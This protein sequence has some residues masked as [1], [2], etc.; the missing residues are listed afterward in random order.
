[1]A[2]HLRFAGLIASAGVALSL[3][4]ASP[5][6][7]SEG[8]ISSVTARPAAVIAAST[9]PSS[10]RKAGASATT[11]TH[12]ATAVPR[13]TGRLAPAPRPP[14]RYAAA[15]WGTC[16]DLQCGRLIGLMLGIGF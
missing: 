10:P 16:L 14:L 8:T 15:N 12:R 2:S 6:A 9:A 7:A 5:A 13:R 11:F 4:C 1:M 3:A